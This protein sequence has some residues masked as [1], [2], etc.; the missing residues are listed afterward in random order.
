MSMTPDDIL[1]AMDAELAT[2][3]ALFVDAVMDYNALARSEPL[4]SR[5][6]DPTPSYVFPVIPTAPPAPAE[7]DT[8]LIALGTPPAPPT[9][10]DA[11]SV[12]RMA[13]DGPMSLVA[14]LLPQSPPSVGYPSAQPMPSYDTAPR[15]PS[16]PGLPVVEIP[17]LLVGSVTPFTRLPV[18]GV[19]AIFRGARPDVSPLA[20]YGARSEASTAATR[21]AGLADAA[22][23]EWVGRLVPGYHE[24]CDGLRHRLKE[25]T[26]GDG[27]AL[28]TAR[29]EQ[30]YVARRMASDDAAE[31]AGREVQATARDAIEPGLGNFMRQAQAWAGRAEASCRAA[32]DV[33]TMRYAQHIRLTQTS[34]NI[35]QGYGDAVRQYVGAGFAVALSFRRQGSAFAAKGLDLLSKQMRLGIRGYNEAVGLYQAEA[36][37][38][39]GIARAALL[40]HEQAKVELQAI[41][42]GLDVDAARLSAAKERLA[43]AGRVLDVAAAERKAAYDQAM[44]HLEAMRMSLDGIQAVGESVAIG[45][46]RQRAFDALLSAADGK[47]SAAGL[48]QRAYSTRTEVRELTRAIDEA[49]GRLKLARDANLID[50]FRAEVA[51]YGAQTSVAADAATVDLARSKLPLDLYEAELARFSMGLDEKTSNARYDWEA[52]WAQFRRTVETAG[53]EMRAYFRAL[54]SHRNLARSIVQGYQQSAE[55]AAHSVMT[56]AG[57]VNRE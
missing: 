23:D 13:P 44:G 37:R 29:A 45:A 27:E 42:A 17:P 26:Q 41:E 25:I 43:V 20:G 50:L 49:A 10:G 1:S 57:V 9:L 33:A 47:L 48:E 8:E 5:P 38:A 2:L 21:V 30:I 3:S 18:P 51:E 4:P 31:R 53:G 28:P 16:P 56:A 7:A 46:E 55:A 32:G 35:A 11:P 36:E 39:D 15:F 22:A 54:Q 12:N 40:G 34:L 52:R 24:V 14:N 6:G 19:E